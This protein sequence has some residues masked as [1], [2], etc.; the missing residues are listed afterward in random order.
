MNDKCWNAT[1]R[2]YIEITFLFVR[3]KIKIPNNIKLWVLVQKNSQ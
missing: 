3:K 2:D 1:E